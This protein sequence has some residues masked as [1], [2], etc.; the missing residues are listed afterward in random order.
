MAMMTTRGISLQAAVSVRLRHVGTEGQTCGRTSTISRRSEVRRTQCGF[1]SDPLRDGHHS[2]VLIKRTL[3]SRPTL[4]RANSI[5][6]FIRDSDPDQI[7]C[8]QVLLEKQESMNHKGGNDIL[9]FRVPSD[10]EWSK[11]SRSSPDSRDRGIEM[12]TIHP[13]HP[14]PTS[15]PKPKV[16]LFGKIKNLGKSIKR[17]LKDVGSFLLSC[18][19]N[20]FRKKDGASNLKTSETGIY[21]S[22]EVEN[23]DLWRYIK[24]A[25]RLM[26]MIPGN[27]TPLTNSL[28]EDSDLEHFEPFEALK[29][30]A[31]ELVVNPCKQDHIVG[32]LFGQGEPEQ[33]NPFFKRLIGD[34][35]TKKLKEIF[36][37]QMDNLKVS[38]PTSLAEKYPGGWDEFVQTLTSPEQKEA[39]EEFQIKLKATLERIPE[40]KRINIII[41]AKQYRKERLGGAENK[42]G[43]VNPQHSS[44]TDNLKI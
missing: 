27:S 18:I 7:K 41:F 29:L 31:W 42:S 1:S 24:K 44:N 5:A 12:K 21:L 32:D 35:G 6:R 40:S 34:P 11:D 4:R 8:D 33:W 30:L 16:G 26:E 43:L 13:L 28:E 39:V 2:P 25:K 20:I 36:V 3:S 37:T 10:E 15:K 17:S 19:L 14:Y 22:G 38:D 9:H 23:D